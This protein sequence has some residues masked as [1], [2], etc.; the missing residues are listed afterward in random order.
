VDAPR[1]TS[2]DRRIAKQ[3]FGDTGDGTFVLR[4]LPS[5]GSEPSTRDSTFLQHDCGT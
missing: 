2:L 4:Y 5:A 3:A 1:I